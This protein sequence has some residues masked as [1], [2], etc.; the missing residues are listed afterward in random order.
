MAEKGF[1]ISSAEDVMNIFTESPLLPKDEKQDCNFTQFRYVCEAL[2]LA[3]HDRELMKVFNYIDK[4]TMDDILT[5]VDYR[6]FF[7]DEQ[8]SHTEENDQKSTIEDKATK[9]KP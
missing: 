5:E 6:N 4:G 1:K 2:G 9:V 7:I 8:S 3:L